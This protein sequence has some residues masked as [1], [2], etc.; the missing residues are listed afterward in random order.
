LGLSNTGFSNT[1]FNKTGSNDLYDMNS[2]N[3]EKDVDTNTSNQ[4]SH[5]SAILEFE[6]YQKQ[7]MTKYLPKYLASYFNNYN[8]I[9]INMIKDN[10]FKDN[11]SYLHDLVSISKV[12]LFI[13][14][15]PGVEFTVEHL[16][17]ELHALLKRLH[18]K[19][20]KDYETIADM[21]KTGYIF[22]SF[23]NVFIH[24]Y[25]DF[26]DKHDAYKHDLKQS[27]FV[28]RKNK[29]HNNI[30]KTKKVESSINRKSIEV[31]TCDLDEVGV[32]YSRKELNILIS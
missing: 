25:N 6:N 20:V 19:S 3:K 5:N 27:K 21:D 16:E 18:G 13:Q 12:G 1:Y 10:L 26:H 8:I 2:S 9:E 14:Y 31:T 24:A 17:F 32:Y 29:N 30:A 7:T 4:T 22:T 11:R 23:K 15:F 28:R